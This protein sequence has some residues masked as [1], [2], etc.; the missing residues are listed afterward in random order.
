[1]N[2]WANELLMSSRRFNPSVLPLKE[3]DRQR[4]LLVMYGGGGHL[5]GIAVNSFLHC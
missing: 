2:T 5:R 1:M 4:P 3:A